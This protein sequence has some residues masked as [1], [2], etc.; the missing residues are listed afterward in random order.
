MAEPIV[1]EC[2]ECGATIGTVPVVEVRPGFFANTPAQPLPVA[3]PN[4]H[5]AERVRAENTP[6]FEKIRTGV[7][8][9]KQQSILRR[10]Q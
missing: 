4:G 10:G 5:V 2:G 6:A 8:F 1:V 7:R 9:D 3:C